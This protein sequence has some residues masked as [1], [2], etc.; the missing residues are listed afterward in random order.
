MTKPGGWRRS[1]IMGNLRTS[2][3][4]VIRRQPM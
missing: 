4:V 2:H 1:L 3:R